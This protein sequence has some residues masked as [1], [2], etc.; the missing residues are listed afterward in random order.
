MAKLASMTAQ[1]IAQKQV[2]AVN[3]AAAAYKAGVQAVKVA[4]GQLAAANRDGYLAGVQANVDKWASN[5][6]AVSLQDWIQKTIT[7]G[8][9]RLGP[10]ITAAQD[11]ITKFWNTWVPILTS[12]VNQVKA[13]P[14]ATFEQRLARMNSMAN[15]LHEMSGKGRG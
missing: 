9:Q 10:G 3:A 2:N 13:M 12:A 8:V 1:Q 4:P 14:K 5:V 11:K 15:L 6:A 7:L